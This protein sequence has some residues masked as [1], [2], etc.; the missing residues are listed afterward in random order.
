MS[1][2]AKRQEFDRDFQTTGSQA[3]KRRGRFPRLALRQRGNDHPMVMF[4]VAVGLAFASMALL[5]ASGGA[6]ASVTRTPSSPA[7]R[8][9]GDDKVSR[10][11]AVPETG[12]VC[13][14]QAWGA[15]NA[16]CLLVIARESGKA[17]PRKVRVIADA[18]PA[19]TTPNIF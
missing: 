14:G 9:Q 17:E 19:R 2:K 10:L 12:V 1:G 16:D 7:E 5:P 11:S 15:E 6:L 8:T 18:Q 4:A 3:P 13:Q